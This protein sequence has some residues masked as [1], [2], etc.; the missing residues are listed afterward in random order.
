MEN[1]D[2]YDPD[3]LDDEGDFDDD[4]VDRIAA[5]AAMQKRDEREGR[6]K[7]KILSVSEYEDPQP[8]NN[9]KIPQSDGKLQTTLFSYFGKI[10]KPSVSDAGSLM[11]PISAPVSLSV[12]SLKAQ[13]QAQAEVRLVSRA[14]KNG[15]LGPSVGSLVWAKVVGYP[16][17]PGLVSYHPTQAREHR[18]TGAGTEIHVQFLGENHRDWVAASLVRPWGQHV[19]V[20]QREKEA[21]WIHGVTL[22]EEAVDMTDEERLALLVTNY[23][24]E[25][26]QEEEES[27][28][29]NSEVKSPVKKKRRKRIVILDTSE[30]EEESEGN[31]QEF[32]VESILG[33]REGHGV[34]EYLIKWLGYDREEDNTWEPVNNL[35]CCDKIKLFEENQETKNT[36][37]ENKESTN[38][39]NLT[40]EDCTNREISA[41]AC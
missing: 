27:R 35:Q 26:E 18:G 39:R 12:S 4:E 19:D 24:G 25:M 8:V 16:W 34:T 28:M 21:A 6:T 32:E 17:W 9:T 36:K 23:D 33:K 13:A 22:A 20:E 30:S 10:N 41:G 11:S 40:K 15:S 3:L 7:E 1:L 37:L 2:K 5:E 31:Q 38:D 29:E 14:S